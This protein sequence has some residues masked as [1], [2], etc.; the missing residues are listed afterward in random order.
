M[1]DASW[2]LGGLFAI[3]LIAT[4]IGRVLARRQPSSAVVEN[5]NARIRSWWILVVIGGAAL[6]AGRL[7]IIALFAFV[8]FLALREFVKLDRGLAV[9]SYSILLMQYGFIAMG[10]I[11]GFLIFIPVFCGLASIWPRARQAALGLLLCVYC[12]S[13]VPALMLLEIPGYEGRMP[14][15]A[16]YVVVV[17]QISDVLQYLWGKLIGRRL[18]AARISP[19]KTVEGSIGGVVSSAMLGGLMLWPITPF[20]RWQA[21]AM[22]LM[23]AGSGF[24]SGLVLSAIKRRR[25]IKDWGSLLEGHGGMLDRMDS[26]CLSAPVFFQMVWWVFGN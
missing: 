1:K 25:G 20:N 18:V 8:S 16:A 23:L 26:L 11:W 22:A 3:L 7:A 12:L 14:L 19:S 10:W 2:I 15:L 24:A 5:L 6:L 9:V 13:H 21:G 17:V 4:I